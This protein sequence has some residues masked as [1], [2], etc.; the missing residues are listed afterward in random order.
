M[1]A[2]CRMHPLAVTKQV[3]DLDPVSPLPRKGAV[4]PAFAVSSR[5]FGGALR[6]GGAALGGYS[7]TSIFPVLAPLN[8]P[9]NASSVLSSPSTTVSRDLTWP[10]ASQP[11]MS[12]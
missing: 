6:A 11:P 5:S 10:V 3:R 9:R 8:R 2:M 4:R 12:R 7:L 1:V